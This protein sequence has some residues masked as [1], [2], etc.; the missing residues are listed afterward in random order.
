MF[1]K[2]RRGA[3]PAAFLSRG[4]TLIELLV[5][6]AIIGI[7]SV[8]GVS[9]Y[10]LALQTARQRAT[11]AT[12]R[13]LGQVLAFYHIE[14]SRFPSCDAGPAV[15]ADGSW[16]ECTAMEIRPRLIPPDPSAILPDLGV[17]DSWQYD[18][19][20]RTDGESYSIISYG[21][22]GVIDAPISVDTRHEFE[23]DIYFEDGRFTASPV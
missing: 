23:L 3:S 17:L 20:Y 18:L 9:R 13:N 15:P 11:M 16:F 2:R 6:V 7:L 19:I 8:I 22:N 10:Q 4:F 1:N 21:K 5:V 14:Q 12:M